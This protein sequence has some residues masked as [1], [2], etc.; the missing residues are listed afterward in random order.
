MAFSRNDPLIDISSTAPFSGHPEAAKRLVFNMTS[1][2]Q[3]SMD[4][5][6][7]LSIVCKNTRANQEFEPN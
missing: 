4:E 6:I 7:F 3:F 1:S 2:K 5:K